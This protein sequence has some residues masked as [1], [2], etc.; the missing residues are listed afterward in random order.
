MTIPSWATTLERKSALGLVLN[1]FHRFV[2]VSPVRGWR[3]A[4]AF[5]PRLFAA[6]SGHVDG[7]VTPALAAVWRVRNIPPEDM[8]VMESINPRP[9]QTL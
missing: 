1:A 3:S 5:D 6:T 9:G 7:A 4:R 8:G 2:I